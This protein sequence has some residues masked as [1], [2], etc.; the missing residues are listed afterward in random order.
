MSWTAAQALSWIICQEPRLFSKWTSDMGPYIK[1]AQSDLAAAIADRKVSAWGRPAPHAALQA[2]PSD[3][4]RLP[5]VPVVVGPCG[6]MVRRQA[7]RFYQG[8]I[9]RDIEFEENEIRKAF[10][11]PPPQTAK[12]WMLKEALHYETQGLKGK[13]DVMIR[14]CCTAVGCTRRQAEA[15]HRALPNYLRRGKGERVSRTP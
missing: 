10:P 12:D 4:F 13:R 8:V 3:L 15:A 9:W 1:Q 11:A 2:V 7:H 14:D 6:E 5:G